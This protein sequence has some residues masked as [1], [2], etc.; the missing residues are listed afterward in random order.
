MSYAKDLH[1]PQE[2]KPVA[3]NSALA[4]S[5]TT[6]KVNPEQLDHAQNIDVRRRSELGQFMTPS[7]IAHFMAS[8]FDRSR[9][10]DIRLLDPGAGLGSL[11]RAFLDAC[12][13]GGAGHR[14]E[15]VAYEIDPGLRDHLAKH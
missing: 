3:I 6:A 5:H 1:Q 11:S 9:F 12:F 13:P 14:A 4:I 2:S 10:A 15:V 8:L 7:Q